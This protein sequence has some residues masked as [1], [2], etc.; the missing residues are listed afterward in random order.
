[1]API[2]NQQTGLIHLLSINGQEITEHNR[3]FNSSVEQSGSDI[4]LSRGNIRRYI[5]KNK[6][7]F[8]LNFTYLPNNTDH[9]VDGRRGRDYLSSLANTRGAVTVSIKAS[10]ADDFKTYT[11]FVNSYSEKLV[12]RD[13]KSA[14]SYYDV[15]IELGEQ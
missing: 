8:S 1:M 14:C 3:K 4:E 6:K 11:C 5:R 7:I 10:P 9:T 15:S 12:R 2:Q 13:I